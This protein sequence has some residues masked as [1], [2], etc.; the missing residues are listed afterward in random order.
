MGQEAEYSESKGDNVTSL[1]KGKTDRQWAKHWTKEMQASEKR[2][3]KYVSRGNQVVRRFVDERNDGSEIESLRR[4]ASSRVNLFHKNVATLQSMLFGSVPKIEV[5]REH[6]DPD[7]DIARVA[8]YLYQR[9]LDADV[10]SSG[11]DL[12]TTLK[13]SLQDRLLPGMGNA[14][15]RYDFSEKDGEFESESCTVEY[16]HWQDFRWGWARTWTEVP[17]L[18]FREW[19]DKEEFKARFPDADVSRV[20]FENQQ[21]EGESNAD[22]VYSKDQSNNV[23]KVQVWEIWNMATREVFWWTKGASEI[24]DKK[25]DPY[26][27]DGFWPCPMPM[28]ANQTTTMLIPTSEF[29]MAQDLYNEID[30]LQSRISILTRACKVVGLYDKGQEGVQRMLTEGVENDLIPVDNWA[31]FA[32]VGGLK[33]VVDWFPVEVVAGVMQTLQQQLGERIELLY[34]VTGMSDIVRGGNTQQYTSDGTNQLKAKFGSINIQALQDEFARF[35]SDLEALKAEIVGKHYEP[36]TIIVHSNATFVPEPDKPLVPQAIALMKSEKVK[37]RVQ[38]RP[39]SIAMVDYAQLKSERTEFLTAMATFLQSSQAMVQ[40]VPQSLP[41]LLEFMKWGMAGFKGANYL[42]G[43]L[44]QA[45]DMA[46]KTPAPDQNAAEKQKQSGEMQKMQMQ[47]R[48]DMEKIQAK[49]QAD[50]QLF[51]TKMQ[52][53]VQKAMADHQHKME[54]AEAKARG[55]IQKIMA[56]LQADL[57]VIGAKLGADI[58]TEQ[59]Q[60]QNAAAEAE[61]DHQHSLTEAAVEHEYTMTELG[62]QHAVDMTEKKEDAKMATDNKP[63]DGEE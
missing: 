47:H 38:I 9:I 26:Q 10:Q 1:P 39:E 52:A 59:A 42:E 31:M 46:K 19:F 63:G 61:V 43:M 58:Q 22:S 29:Y 16:V 3:R 45:I 56:D 30:E 25:D 4:D 44:D 62:A 28:I 33:G 60:A 17:W 13:A 41:V 36:D 32:E 54:Q 21:P 51:Q 15:V 2:L 5:S 8:S 40:A 37:W 55:D 18:S 11:H 35:S 48:Y 14:R 7:D 53:E 57:K 20:E 27:L 24:L 49:G 12:A 23:Q 50:M 6:Q 34:E